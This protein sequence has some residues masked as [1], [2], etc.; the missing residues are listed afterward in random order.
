MS[1]YEFKQDGKCLEINTAKTPTPWANW[2]FNDEYTMQISQRLCGESF[3]VNQ[4]RK[5]PVLSQQKEFFVKTDGEIY[6]LCAGLGIDYK[7]E[8]YIH[9]TSATEVF[10]KFT[11][12]VTTFVPSKGKRELWR[13]EVKNVSDSVKNIEVFAAFPFANIDYQG[14]ECEFLPKY[15]CFIKRCFPYYIKYEEYE[16]AQ[17]NVQYTYAASN[18]PCKSAECSMLRYSG[19]DNPF[20]IPAMVEKGGSCK[21]SDFENCVAAFHHSF[22]AKE[23]ISV[24]YL[25]CDL[26]DRNQVGTIEFPDFDAELE[27]TRAYWENYMNSFIVN[28]E[29]KPLEYMTNYWLKK[30]VIFLTKHNRG[31]VYCPVRNQLQDALGYA[32]ID[33]EDAFKY[34]MN[35]LERQEESGYIKQWYMTDNS[36]ATGLCRINHSDAPIWLVMCIVEII[37]QTKRAELFDLQV[38]YYNSEKSDS[39]IN[40]LKKAVEYMST[41]LGEHGLCLMKDGDWTDPINGA[42]RLGK[43]ESAW[44]S[45]ALVHVAKKLN[46]I[47]YEPWIAEFIEKLT[48]SINEYCWNE[49]RYIVGYDDNGV[50]FGK[51]GDAEGELFINTQVWALIAEICDEERIKIIKNTVEELKTEHGYLL[52][53]PAFDSYNSLWGKISVK[54]KGATENGSI[55]SHATMFKAYADCV[56]GDKEGALDTMISLLPIKDDELQAPLYLP[57]YYFGIEGENYMRSSCVFSAG[58]PA[59]LLWIMKKFFM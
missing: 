28:L 53:K 20:A 18:K 34:A 31:G 14:L 6:R 41:Q 13:V 32:M 16:G 2:L 58:A 11:A 43:G 59:W 3:S 30:Q 19:G 5:K 42:G 10:D 50:P 52:L 12:T 37:S 8:H 21:R 35:V 49:D 23:E 24:D 33:P 15:N 51:K 45:M 47:S 27:A 4:Y 25:I 54:Q 40:H 48:N 1:L 9:K 17:Q 55:Y 7:C 22:D 57:N 46:S 38:K 39:V 29:H 44:N 56:V 36:P 26:K